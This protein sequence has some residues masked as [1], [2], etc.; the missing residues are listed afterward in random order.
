MDAEVKQIAAWVADFYKGEQM[1]RRLARGGMGKA[2]H[3]AWTS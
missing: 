2:K 3:D 1:G